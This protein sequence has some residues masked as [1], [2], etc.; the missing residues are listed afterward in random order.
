MSVVVRDWR[1]ENDVK[2]HLLRAGRAFCLDSKT[3]IL[4]DSELN[5]KSDIY[6]A[7]NIKTGEL[8]SID[9]N[10]DVEP[11]L[12]SVRIMKNAEEN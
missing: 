12:L 10:M 1:K 2:L 3:Y 7:L 4:S 6:W 11:V 8:D 5:K 9:I